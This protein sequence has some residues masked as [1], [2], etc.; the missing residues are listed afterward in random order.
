MSMSHAE[1]AEWCADESNHA[2]DATPKDHAAG[3]LP[4]K[5][6]ER[7]LDIAQKCGFVKIR[8]A[9]DVAALDHIHQALMALLA[10][11]P[12]SAL[13]AELRESQP[14]EDATVVEGLSS[15]LRSLQALYLRRRHKPWLGEHSRA[16]LDMPFAPPYNSSAVVRAP[17]VA[18]LVEMLLGAPRGGGLGVVV[19]QAAH[20]MVGPRTGPQQMHTDAAHYTVVGEAVA[21]HPVTSLVEEATAADDAAKAAFDAIRTDMERGARTYALNVQMPLTEVTMAN[22]PTALCPAT[23]SEAFCKAF[24]GG[25]CKPRQHAAGVSAVEAIAAYAT[26]SRSCVSARR[27]CMGRLGWAIILLYDSRLIHWGAAH[28]GGERRAIDHLVHV[29][30]RLVH[31]GRPRPVAR[32]RRRG[33]P[34]AWRVAARRARRRRRRRRDAPPVASRRRPQRGAVSRHPRRA[35]RAPA[36][37]GADLHHARKVAGYAILLYGIYS[38]F[39]AAPPPPPAHERQSGARSATNKAAGK[40]GVEPAGIGTGAWR[41]G[42]VEPGWNDRAWP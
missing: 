8:Q 6:V 38:F 27:A 24:L 3:K 36:A 31:G 34:L 37:R 41:G 20:I 19:E 30:A 10:K 14:L 7:A 23:H 15:W 42:C 32:R 35:P 2:L 4:R 16:M 40:S 28:D 13:L 21:V 33:R 29:R 17:L 25:I 5:S 1:L 18:P 22:G 11:T 12:D 26:T 9:V 39:A